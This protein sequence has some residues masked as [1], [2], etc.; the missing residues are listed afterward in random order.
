MFT[1][2]TA[3]EHDSDILRDQ[4]SDGALSFCTE[5]ECVN[6]PL[7][8]RCGMSP[9]CGE[10]VQSASFFG[11]ILYSIFSVNGI[12]DAFQFTAADVDMFRLTIFPDFERGIPLQD[13]FYGC[14]AQSTCGEE[15]CYQ[16][17]LCCLT[18]FHNFS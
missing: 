5:R 9:F 18:M 12:G 17:V 16:Q 14:T 10:E 7:P 13:I 3:F 15:K 4:V 6:I 11:G 2:Q 1:E 8:D